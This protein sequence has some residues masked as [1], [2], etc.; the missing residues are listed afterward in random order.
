M[1]GNYRMGAFGWLAGSTIE[2]F[3][4]PNA[5]LWD[6]RLLLEFAQR[7]GPKFGGNPSEIGVWGE[8]AGAGSILHHLTMSEPPVFKRAVMQSPAYLWQWDRSEEGYTNRIFRN[9]TTKA[10]CPTNGS[11]AVD[12]LRKLSSA[13]LQKWNQEI[14]FEEHTN[15]GLIAFNPAVDGKLIKQLPTSALQSGKFSLSRLDH[16]GCSEI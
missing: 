4:T 14:I 1:T 16:S 5:G 9:L 12:C 6:Q 8:S 7:Y 10:G 2:E 13:D 3:G 15:T 11:E